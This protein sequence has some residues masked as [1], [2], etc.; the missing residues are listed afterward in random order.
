MLRCRDTPVNP[1]EEVRRQP[2]PSPIVTA[3]R[4]LPA[5]PASA[6]APFGDPAKLRLEE[7]APL[8]PAAP[9]T[10]NPESL[11]CVPR[12][13]PLAA[14]TTLPLPAIS[15]LHKLWAQMQNVTRGSA[16]AIHVVCM[17]LGMMRSSKS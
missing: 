10:G 14:L 12:P 16:Y 17:P 9:A 5:A 6:Q 2:E 15:R 11:R 8:Q 1:F 4:P 3:R 7:M 13:H